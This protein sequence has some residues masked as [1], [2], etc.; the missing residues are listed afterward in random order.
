VGRDHL[1][2][3]GV[4]GRLVLQW[5]FKKCDGSVDCID[6]TQDRDEW[7]ALVNA[8]IN[9]RVSRKYFQEGLCS[10]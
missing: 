2:A 4:D 7:R 6:L 10:T 1:E 3:L 9:L 5:V 8:V